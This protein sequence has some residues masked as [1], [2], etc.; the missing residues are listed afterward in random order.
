MLRKQRLN[1]EKEKEGKKQKV[2]TVAETL[3]TKPRHEERDTQPV[4]HLQ[5]FTIQSENAL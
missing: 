3:K 1:S 4:A 2:Q 5:L